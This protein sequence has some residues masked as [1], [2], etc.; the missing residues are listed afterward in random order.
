MAIGVNWKEVWKPVW[1]LV[2]EQASTVPVS[3]PSGGPDTPLE[4]RAQWE[5]WRPV[6]VARRRRIEQEE[7]EREEKRRDRER[8]EV[9]TFAASVRDEQERK[10]QEAIAVLTAINAMLD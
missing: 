1:K 6:R 7:A 2:W 4:A 9:A 10:I 5:R 3:M 8:E